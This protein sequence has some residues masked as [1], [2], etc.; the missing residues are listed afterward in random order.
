MV[1]NGATGRGSGKKQE[2]KGW[3][4]GRGEGERG[5]AGSSLSQG[6]CEAKGAL[7]VFSVFICNP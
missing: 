3:G 6:T 5:E 7:C 4:G 1:E 2:G